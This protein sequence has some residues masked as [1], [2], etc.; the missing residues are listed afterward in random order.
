MHINF[1]TISV[2][3]I[4]IISILVQIRM[5][6]M[7]ETIFFKFSWWY[8]YSASQKK[9]LHCLNVPPNI[10]FFKYFQKMFI[11]VGS[12]G[13][14]LSND[15]KN[16]TILYAWVSRSNV[17]KMEQRIWDL[18]WLLSAKLRVVKRIVNLHFPMVLCQFMKE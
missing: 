3:Y 2:F 16:L 18:F 15:T 7:N 1:H 13:S 9:S 6:F 14:L 10:Y 5:K 12:Q 8:Q 17:C 11:P 4:Y